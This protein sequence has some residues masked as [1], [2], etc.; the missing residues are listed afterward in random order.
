MAKRAKHITTT[1]KVPHKWK[2]VHDMVGYNYRMPNLNAAL[3]CAQMEVLPKYLE[4]K[5]QLAAKYRDF[6]TGSEFLFVDE[7]EYAQSNYWLNAVICPN[8]GGRDELIKITNDAGVM[9]RPVWKLM[10]RLPMFENAHCGDLTVSEWLEE[11]LLNL[12]SSPVL[13]NK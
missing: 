11:R 3:G 1:A 9:T 5:R 2:F 13:E 12:P 4:Q 8:K 7:P 10:H 6:F